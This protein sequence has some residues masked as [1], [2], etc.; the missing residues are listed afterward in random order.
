MSIC[1]LHLNQ[2]QDNGPDLGVAFGVDLLKTS[3]SMLSL[4]GR[5]FFRA[6]GFTRGQWLYVT[7]LGLHQFVASGLGNPAMPCITAGCAYESFFGFWLRSLFC[8]CFQWLQQEWGGL[9]MFRLRK[10][11]LEIVCNS[12]SDIP[13]V[14][15]CA[16]CSIV[17][18]FLF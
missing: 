5:F 7:D 2:D 3:K 13:P 15:L 14:G 10:E 9:G 8:K 1:H 6:L 17:C 18:Q 16:A 12:G 4:C 11:T